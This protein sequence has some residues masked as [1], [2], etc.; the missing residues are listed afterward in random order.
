MIMNGTRAALAAPGSVTGI[1]LDVGQDGLTAQISVTL[2]N[3]EL[4]DLFLSE[5]TAAFQSPAGLTIGPLKV[6]GE[7][8]SEEASH[9]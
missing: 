9:V 4:L 2:K 6:T 1:K 8:V 3:G 7:I 5:F